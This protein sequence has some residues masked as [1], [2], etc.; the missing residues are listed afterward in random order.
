MLFRYFKA[1]MNEHNW[2]PKDFYN[3]MKEIKCGIPG[4]HSRMAFKISYDWWSWFWGIFRECVQSWH[5]RSLEYKGTLIS[6]MTEPMCDSNT[7][8]FSALI[9]GIEDKEVSMYSLARMEWLAMEFVFEARELL[10][11]Y[12]WTK[13]LT[14]WSALERHFGCTREQIHLDVAFAPHKMRFSQGELESTARGAG[15]CIDVL[16]VAWSG[17]EDAT[18]TSLPTIVGTAYHTTNVIPETMG[19]NPD[20]PY[21]ETRILWRHHDAFKDLMPKAATR[22]VKK[23]SL[24]L[25]QKV[26]DADLD[27]RVWHTDVLH[28]GHPV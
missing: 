8:L 19:D 1:M 24:P 25:P 6:L 27:P 7:Q 12:K 21:P 28:C 10:Y 17:N 16:L 4:K 15:E 11:D 22:F 20:Q 2:A 26:Q 9:T 13:T 14:P 23:H 5:T 3:H 18:A